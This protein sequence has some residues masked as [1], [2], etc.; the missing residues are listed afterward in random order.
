MPW[1]VDRGFVSTRFGKQRH[2][3]YKNNEIQSNGVRITTEK[4]SYARAVF[5]GTVLLIQVTTGN[6]KNG[7]SSARK[8]HNTLQRL[9]KYIC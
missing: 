6:K 5:G 8:L 3:I 9:R 4:G 2:P 1:P 7:L